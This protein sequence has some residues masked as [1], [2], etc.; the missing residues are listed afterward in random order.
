MDLM[1]MY[2]EDVAYW[3]QQI[4]Y[5]AESELSEEGAKIIQKLASRLATSAISFGQER[6]K[7]GLGR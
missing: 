6:A 5:F 3:L 2:E 7:G 4:G 1:K